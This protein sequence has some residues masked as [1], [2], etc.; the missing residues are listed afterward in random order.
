MTIEV[1]STQRK[2]LSDLVKGVN[3]ADNSNAMQ[4]NYA[5]ITLTDKAIVEPIGLPV[6][7]IDTDS[8]WRIY[9]DS[10]AS[11]IALAI[12][13]GTSTLP[14]KAPIAIVVGDAYGAGFNS[15]DIDYSTGAVSTVLFRGA[16]NTG[17]ISD[18]IAY[19]GITSD[20]NVA[21]FEAQLEAQGIMVIENAEVID[22]SLTD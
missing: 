17:V 3:T 22:S 5:S 4:F 1:V 19:Q 2:Y 9:G 10:T 13:A 8:E 6:V 15:K 14:N 21:A 11:Q 16:N 12:T 20:S 18:R 7:W